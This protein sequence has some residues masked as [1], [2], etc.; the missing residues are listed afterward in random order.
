MLSHIHTI[1]SAFNSISLDEMDAV[2]L[3]KRTDTKFIFHANQLARILELTKTD[4]RVLEINNTRIS[5]YQT[6]YYDTSDFALYQAHLHG[7]LNRYKVRYR[8]YINSHTGNLEVKFKS[9][10][11][12]T[13]KNRLKASN[14]LLA[15]NSEAIQFIKTLTPFDPAT[16]VP[17]LWV[18]YSRITLV[19]VNTK[20]RL[21]LDLHIEFINGTN[22]KNLH[23]LIIAEVKKDQAKGSPFFLI[24]KHLAIKEVSLSKYCIAMAYTEPT[25]KT[26]RFKETLRSIKK[27]T[28]YD[29]ITN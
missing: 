16:L 19:N 9:N 12:K 10:K 27:I 2:K 11:D 29:F 8:N 6:L 17:S 14:P 20:E 26:N 28:D 1:L 15:W 3:M 21:T 18:N 13:I 24:M 23:P 7:K 5:D 25:I 4:Y 22:T